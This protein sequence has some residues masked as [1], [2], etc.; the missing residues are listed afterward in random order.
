MTEQPPP[1]PLPLPTARSLPHWE[2]CRRGELLVQRCVDC[3]HYVFIPQPA[4]TRCLSDNLEWVP[5]SGSGTIYSYTVVHRP[6]QPV[7]EVPYAIAIIE[8][9]EGWHM[10]SNIVGCPPEDVRIGMPVEVEFRRMSDEI[11]L[12]LF[13][14]VPPD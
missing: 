2:G 7:F 5:S 13:H 14:P 6:Q 1:I 3:G 11:T 4:C 12:P 9:A 10:L 8:M